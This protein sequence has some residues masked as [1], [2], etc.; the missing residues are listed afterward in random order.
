[1][2]DEI[3]KSMTEEWLRNKIHGLDGWTVKFSI[4]CND[5]IGDDLL[6]AVEEMRLNGKIRGSIN[7]DILT[8]IHKVGCLNSYN[9]FQVISLCNCIYKLTG[10][11]TANSIRNILSKGIST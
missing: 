11:I 1:M 2:N 8:S 5:I 7:S 3:F 10:R 4:D 6:Q 9:D